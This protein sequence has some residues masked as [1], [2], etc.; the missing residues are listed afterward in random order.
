MEVG[1][2]VPEEQAVVQPEV[3]VIDSDHEVSDQEVHSPELPVEEEKVEAE[4]AE[5]EK[6]G[7]PEVW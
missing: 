3:V 7:E 1:G 6:Q 4:P 2:R 5:E